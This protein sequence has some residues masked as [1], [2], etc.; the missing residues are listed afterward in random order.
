MFFDEIYSANPFPQAINSESFVF[1]LYVSRCLPAL[2]EQILSGYQYGRAD[3]G[4][5][6]TKSTFP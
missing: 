3:N 1:L 6:D 2:P 5:G 4:A